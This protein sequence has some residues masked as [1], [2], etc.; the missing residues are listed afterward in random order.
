MKT[1]IEKRLKE[2]QTMNTSMTSQKS[3]VPSPLY[4]MAARI[5]ASRQI[6]LEERTVLKTA[7]LEASLSEEEHRMVT[8]TYRALLRGRFK[9]V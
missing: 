4:E 5:A 1:V 8:R 9:L 3:F 2:V 7:F 6:T